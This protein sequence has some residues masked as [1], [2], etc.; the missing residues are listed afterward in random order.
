M[1]GYHQFSVSSVQP[2]RR[3]P[4]G[5]VAGAIMIGALLYMIVTGSPMLSM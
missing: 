1:G 4:W 2:K 3:F 5:W